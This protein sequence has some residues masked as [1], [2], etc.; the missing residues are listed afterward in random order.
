MT[1]ERVMRD[2]RRLLFLMA[3]FFCA[4]GVAIL[5]NPG[6]PSTGVKYDAVG[7]VLLGVICAVAGINHSFWL[8]LGCIVVWLLGAVS[9]LMAVRGPGAVEFVVIFIASG[10]IYRM[11]KYH[12]VQE[13][14]EVPM[15][16]NPLTPLTQSYSRNVSPKT[17]IFV[18]VVLI[19]SVLVL[20]PWIQR[21]KANWSQELEKTQKSQGKRTQ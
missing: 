7:V 20:D 21:L 2:S 6:G 1:H 8:R 19:I 3:A 9:F 11:I 10:L 4:W 5:F 14:P 17:L 18:V 13:E 15:E 16:E 12:G